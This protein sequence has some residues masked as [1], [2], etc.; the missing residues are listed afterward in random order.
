MFILLTSL[1]SCL[2]GCALRGRRCHCGTPPPH[3]LVHGPNGDGGRK[4]GGPQRT[5][6]LLV[7]RRLHRKKSGHTR[8]VRVEETVKRHLL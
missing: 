1:G 2:G 6:G 3:D 8:E 4:L 5:H 7:P